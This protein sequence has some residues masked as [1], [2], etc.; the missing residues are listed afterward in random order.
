MAQVTWLDKH[1]AAKNSAALRWSNKNRPA[2]LYLSLFL[3]L[4][5]FQNEI[6]QNECAYNC[7]ACVCLMSIEFASGLSAWWGWAYVYLY[8]C[9]RPWPGLNRSNLANGIGHCYS[10]LII[11]RRHTFISMCA[12]FY[13]RRIIM[14]NDFWYPCSKFKYVSTHFITNGFFPSLWSIV[15]TNSLRLSSGPFLSSM[16]H[17]GIVESA[18]GNEKS[19]PLKMRNR[20]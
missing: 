20:Y 5:S 4:H 9:V 12:M 10:R 2:V 15:S 16:L 7:C 11:N 1:T 13:V 3:S 18:T 6:T 14:I 8:E 17:L 19:C